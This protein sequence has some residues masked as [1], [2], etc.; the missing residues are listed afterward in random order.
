MKRG[1]DC[2]VCGQQ[3]CGLHESVLAF[4]NTLGRCA[5][6]AV[7]ILMAALALAMS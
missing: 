2:P 5:F 4:A 7:G 1:I 3:D 6:V